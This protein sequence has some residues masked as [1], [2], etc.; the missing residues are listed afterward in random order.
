MS[1]TKS[2]YTSKKIVATGRLKQSNQLVLPAAETSDEHD[3]QPLK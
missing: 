3:Q 1:V 2:N